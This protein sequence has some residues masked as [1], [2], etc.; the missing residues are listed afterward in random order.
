MTIGDH[1]ALPA[2]GYLSNQSMLEA[3]LKADDEIMAVDYAADLKNGGGGHHIRLGRSGACADEAVC[4]RI[5]AA[6]QSGKPAAAL[7]ER[8]RNF[9]AAQR[10]W[11]GPVPICSAVISRG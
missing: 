11:S 6:P 4:G 3:Y 10:M 7:R 8:N 9:V 5:F 1:A 2:A